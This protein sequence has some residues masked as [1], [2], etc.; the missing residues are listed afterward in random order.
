MSILNM[1]LPAV[2]L[3]VAPVEQTQ[4][5]PPTLAA[6]RRAEVKLLAERL[7]DT[8]WAHLLGGRGLG[9]RLAGD[10][11][12]SSGWGQGRAK[13]NLPRPGTQPFV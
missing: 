1:A 7:L 6:R 5:R 11:G 13:C 10:F 4:H 2:I 3:L 12:A 9:L 8:C